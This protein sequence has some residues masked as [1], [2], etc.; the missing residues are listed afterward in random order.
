MTQELATNAP[1]S[2][3]DRWLARI[4]LLGASL[5]LLTIGV[6]RFLPEVALFPTA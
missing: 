4:L 3:T 2:N 6:P 1:T 5:V